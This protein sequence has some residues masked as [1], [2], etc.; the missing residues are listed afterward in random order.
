MSAAKA[1]ESEFL[2][3]R[4]RLL[5]IAAAFD[6]LDR[7]EGEPIDDPRMTR[8]REAMAV[9]LQENGDRAEKIQL[10]FSR[11]YDEDWSMKFGLTL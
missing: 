4:A 5:D 2:P 8:I 1:L 6:R 7:A 9:L 11:A 3:L 10:V